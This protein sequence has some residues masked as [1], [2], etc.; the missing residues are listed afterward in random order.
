MKKTYMHIYI[1]SYKHGLIALEA[2]NRE[3]DVFFVV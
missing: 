2:G 1:Y 3:T